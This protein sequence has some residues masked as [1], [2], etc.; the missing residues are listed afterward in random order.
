MPNLKNWLFLVVLTFTQP[1]FMKEILDQLVQQSPMDWTILITALL[2]VILA[3]KESLWCWFFGIIS[4]SLWAYASYQGQLYADA[5]LQLF[6]VAISFWGIYQWQFSQKEDVKQEL[7]VTELKWK[8]HLQIILLGILISLPFGYCLEEYTYAA[9]T[10]L[11]SMTSVFAIMATFMVARKILSNWLYWIVIDGIYI[12]L[13][14]SREME[15]FAF[16]MVIYIFIAIFGYFNWR[17]D[18]VV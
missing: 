14:W 10:Y 15:L 7:K 6:Y 13:Y 9:A 17:K 5:V 11:D 4:C 18:F 8:Q 16:I 2:Y 3:A 12:Y 1:I